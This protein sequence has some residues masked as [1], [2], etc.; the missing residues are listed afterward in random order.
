MRI[1]ILFDK[2]SRDERF[3]TGWGISYLV[4]DDI[5][6]DTGEKFEYLEHNAKLMGVDLGKIKKIVLSSE[7]WEHRGGLGELLKIN[8]DT[9]VYSCPGIESKLEEKIKNSG[10]NLVKVDTTI[11]IRENV[12]CTGP[13]YGYD[14]GRRIWEQ[15]IVVLTKGKLVLICGCSQPGVVKMIEEVKK[16]FHKD[17]KFILG[18]FHLIEKERRIIKYTVEQI[19]HSGIEK[20]GPGHCTGFEGASLLEEVFRNNFIPVEVGREIEI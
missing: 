3:K 9:T 2:D 16:I 15:A 4:D 20:V 6:F 8:R 7:R 18:G 14:G 13:I 10:V 5:L 17:V 11:K 12:Y 1:K 19:V